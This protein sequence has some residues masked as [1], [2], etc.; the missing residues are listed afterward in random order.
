MD[1]TETIKNELQNHQVKLIEIQ[2]QLHEVT[3]TIEELQTTYADMKDKLAFE[4]GVIQSLE[5]ALTLSK[6]DLSTN[7]QQGQKPE[8]K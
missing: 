6:A 4:K 1:A 8:D 2:S 3:Q 5:F 7:K